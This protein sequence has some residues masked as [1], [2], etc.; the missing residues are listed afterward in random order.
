[1]LRYLDFEEEGDFFT[2]KFPQDDAFLKVDFKK[3]MLIYPE[4]EGKGLKIHERQTCNF[5][6][7]E[8][9]VVFECVHRL[10][11]KGYKPK[12]IEL[13]PR[14]KLGHGASG[15]RA[16]IL[17]KNQQGKPLLL[18]ECKTA[19]K[20]FNKAWKETQLDGGQLFTYAQQISATEF[21]CLYASDFDK[22]TQELLLTQ[23]IIAHKDNED[24]LKQQDSDQVLQ[25]F[26]TASNVIQ[27][28]EVWKRTYNLESTTSGIFEDNIQAY[29]IGKNKYTLKEDTQPLT[30][31]DTRKKYHEFR[32]IL[33]QHSIARRETAFEVLVNLFLCKIVDEQENP[34]NLSL[35]WKGIAYDNYFD[36]VDR[37]QELYK[38]GMRKFLNEDITY[39]SSQ[40]INDAFWAVKNDKNATKKTIQKYFRELKFFSN[41]AFSLINVHNETLFKRNAKVLVKIMGNWQRLRLKTDDQ[42]QFLG[43]M[44]EY[45]LDNSI[46]QSEGQFFTPMPICKFIVSALPLEE[47]VKNN[48]DALRVIDYACGSGHFLNEYAHQIKPLVEKH[49]E[50]PPADYYKTIY[51]IEKE[52][53]LAK[54]AKV[55]AFMYGQDQI[56]ILERDALN[57]IEEVKP[58]SFDVL[59]ANPPFAVEGF[60]ENLSDKVKEKYTLIETTGFNSNTKLIQ[61]FFIEKAKQLIAPNGVLGLILPSSVLSNTD[62]THIGT[63]EIILKY[64]DLVS[65][66]E[67]GGKTFGKTGTQTVIFFLRRKPNKPEQAEHYHNRAE[68]FFEGIPA[69]DETQKVYKDLPFVKKY[70]AHIKVKFEDYLLLLNAQRDDNDLEILMQYEVF[71]Q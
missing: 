13:E 17:V 1:M 32:T 59:V 14:W 33:R 15:G 50:A 71:Q 5:D 37:L 8:N 30:A 58:E 2:K 7:N 18:I 12:H 38:I 19:G 52:D 31:K 27:R 9:F 62:N 22:K 25:S 45:F 60:L 63:R 69:E 61:C 64:F 40:Q 66:V 36:F 11:A 46:K 39:I 70:C 57:D 68:L 28:Y 43:D 41:N 24:I 10:L 48:K 55:S 3:K 16:D 21:L 49:K 53:R 35:Y 47:K 26:K 54:V 65:L 44:F 4:F 34:H 23:Q 56:Q 42:N 67:L 20:Q 29:Q 6:Q 51:G